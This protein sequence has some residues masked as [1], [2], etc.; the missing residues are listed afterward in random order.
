MRVSEWLWLFLVQQ[1][2]IACRS[3]GR[4]LLV[5]GLMKKSIY[6]LK[7]NKWSYQENSDW[8][9]VTTHCGGASLFGGSVCALSNKCAS[10]IK[11][12]RVW[13]LTLIVF[14]LL[15]ELFCHRALS[16]LDLEFNLEN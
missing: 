7:S 16:K 9:S 2:I 14:K 11:V 15:N 4:V 8:C 5:N 13:R 12:H 3:V 10:A 1:L 6:S